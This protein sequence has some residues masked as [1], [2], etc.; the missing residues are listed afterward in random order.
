MSERIER[1]IA[2]NEATQYISPEREY[3]FSAFVPLNIIDVALINIVDEL[4]NI[5]VALIN[6]VIALN[7]IVVELNNIVDFV[8]H[9]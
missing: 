9:Q 3:F 1:I 6:I 8:P 2:E 5:V 4:N 7:N